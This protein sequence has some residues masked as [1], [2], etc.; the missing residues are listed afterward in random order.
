MAKRKNPAGVAQVTR[1]AS[2]CHA[3]RGPVAGAGEGWVWGVSLA[4]LR[5]A[6]LPRR[7]SGDL[8]VKDAEKFIGGAV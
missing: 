5:D 3:G 1:T 4:T 8:R 2:T 6:L 7:I